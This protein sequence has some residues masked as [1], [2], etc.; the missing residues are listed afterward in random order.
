MQDLQYLQTSGKYSGQMRKNFSNEEFNQI[1][2]LTPWIEDTSRKSLRERVFCILNNITETPKCVECSNKSKFHGDSYTSF[3]SKE[4]RYRSKELKEKIKTKR[5]NSDKNSFQTKL[6]KSEELFKQ[7]RELVFLDKNGWIRRDFSEGEFKEILL[8][9][10]WIEDTSRKSIRERVS[11]ILNNI[12]ETP[13]CPVCNKDNKFLRNGKYSITCSPSCGIKNPEVQTKTKLTKLEKYGSETFVNP[14]K[15]KNTCLESYGVTHTSKLPENR[16]GALQTNFE[17]NGSR[18]YNNRAGSFVT[19]LERYGEINPSYSKQIRDIISIKI[20]NNFQARRNIEGTDYV[21]VV[22]ILHFP[23]HK[24]V[25]IGLSGDFEKRSKSLISDFGEYTIV[26]IIETHECF[27]LESSLH[28]KFS[29]YRMCL[30][31]GT[32][33]TEFFSDEI[34]EKIK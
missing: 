32:G 12:T 34:L 31:E 3:C 4:C 15:A 20:A 7:T 27:K 9:T 5:L 24:A 16:E 1:C 10:P 8:L 29:E 6:L 2:S 33:R 28:E 21:G 23:Q 26:D 14:D 22:Y 25:K 30:D 17:R 18:N 11:C 13:K 19:C